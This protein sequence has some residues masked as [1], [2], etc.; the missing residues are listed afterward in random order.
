MELYDF[1]KHTFDILSKRQS[2][3]LQAPTGSGK[4]WAAL[5]PFI[6][7]K[8]NS[9][10]DYFPRQCIY[11]VPMRVLA[12]Q[13]ESE[14]RES[15]NCSV[16]IQTG[17]NPSD[18]KLMNG[19]IIFTTI[20]QTLSN[21]LG[22]P[23]ALSQSQANLNAGAIFS[24]YLIFDEFHLFPKDGALETTL[25]I[26]RLL[27]ELVPF[28]LMTATFSSTLLN[29][30]KT[31]LNAE[32]V[33]VSAEELAQIPSQKNKIRRFHTIES[34]LL[35]ESVLRYH[36][37]RSIAICN[38][39]ERSQQLYIELSR[40]VAPER[41]ILLHSRFTFE[42]RNAKE[43]MV[44]REFGKCKK[45]WSDQDLILIATQVIEVGLDI[46]CQALHTEIAPAASILQRAGRCARFKDECGDV[47]VYDVPLNARNEPNYA[48]YIA[49]GE[50]ELCQKTWKAFH[51]RNGTAL[52][53]CHEQ[54]I[55]DQVHTDV[56]RQML[57]KM[58][59]EE[60]VIWSKMTRA[61]MGDSSV[62]R[63]LIR[64]VDSRT[65]LVHDKPESF[66]NPFICKGFS[67]WQ[68]TLK[69][70]F[71][72]LEEW[73]K[74]KG[75]DWS[76][77]Y[78]VEI[79]DEEDSRTPIHYQWEPVKC[80]NDI[81]T[82]FLFV[83]HP[84]LVNYDE[85]LGFCFTNKG[86]EYY[87]QPSQ[88]T[89][90]QRDKFTYQLETYVDH[91]KNMIRIYQRDLADKVAYVAPRLEKKLGLPIGE[92]DRAIRLAIALHDLGKLDVRWQAWIRAYQAEIGEPIFDDTFMAVHSHTENKE[93]EEAAKRINIQRSPHAGEGAIAGARIANNI[94]QGNEGLRRAVITAIAKHHSARTETFG[95]YKLNTN[96]EIALRSALKIAGFDGNIVKNLISE[97]PNTTLEKHILRDNFNLLWLPYLLIVRN[98]RLADGK[99]QEKKRCINQ[100]IM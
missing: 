12:N 75:L 21:A 2:V 73:R 8:T 6:Y 28:V 4:T 58:K 93:H 3:I 30:L 66:D 25:Q 78:P 62:R 31:Y 61:N 72:D 50:S 90:K 7:H 87:T 29:E 94:T 36:D 91:V 32:I 98:L 79:K 100:F 54:E 47:Y 39:V 49:E 97:N 24:S 33:T 44:R 27:K 95:E 40:Q 99:S 42:D 71:N 86:G 89:E 60:G 19:D 48:P 63:D 45:T 38:T 77:K 18:P 13:F 10:S 80:I 56:D 83:I 11:S 41:L 59:Q 70:K 68:G 34:L 92:I 16:A 82:G 81:E 52:N 9:S 65:I 67:L 1:Q 5:H 53:F 43:E 64:Q 26:L 20:D 46:T 96:A 37:H 88:Q 69:G 17:D 55:I 23:Y 85:K 76:L 14:Y 15:K 51:D 35:A 74:S 84:S 22:V 57:E